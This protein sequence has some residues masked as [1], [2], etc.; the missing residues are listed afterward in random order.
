MLGWLFMVMFPGMLFGI[1]MGFLCVW[2]DERKKRRA[3]RN[4]DGG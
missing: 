3:R 2:L 1:P 4:G